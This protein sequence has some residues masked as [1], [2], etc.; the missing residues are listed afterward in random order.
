MLI[1]RVVTCI[2][3]CELVEEI[4]PIPKEHWNEN[5]ETRT[6]LGRATQCLQIMSDWLKVQDILILYRK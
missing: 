3:I 5:T 2:D 1:R 4:G 6:V